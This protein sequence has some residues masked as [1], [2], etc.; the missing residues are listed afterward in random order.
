MPPKYYHDFRWW[1]F[2]DLELSSDCNYLLTT[3]HKQGHYFFWST[4]SSV[5]DVREFNTT[6]KELKII[7]D[8]ATN[9]SYSN[10]D[11]YILYEK[12]YQP[13]G[14][15]KFKSEGYFIYDRLTGKTNFIKNCIYA[16]FVR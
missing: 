3:Y 13:F 11:K 1:G 4:K 10:D 7:A 6:A 14:F 5:S 16:K 9:P 15:R 2:A 12:V 8:F